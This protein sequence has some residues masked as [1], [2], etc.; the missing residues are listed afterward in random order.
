MQIDPLCGECAKLGV[1]RLWTQRDHIQALANGGPDTDENTQGLCDEHHKAKTAKDMGYKQ[2]LT[3]GP[4]GWP[5][6]G[7]DKG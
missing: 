5:V 2:R 1:V 7:N 6:G 4:D 3:I